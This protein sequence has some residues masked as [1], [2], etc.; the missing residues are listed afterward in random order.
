MLKRINYMKFS[1]ILILSIILGGCASSAGFYSN[2]N[3]DQSAVL[4][5]KFPNALRI[6]GGNEVSVFFVKVDEKRIMPNLMTGDVRE[7]FVE[8]GPHRIIVGFKAG[9]APIRVGCVQVEIV[10][11]AKAVYHF[12]AKPT[13]DSFHLEVWN[14]DSERTEPKLIQ[15]LIAPVTEVVRMQVH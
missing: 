5:S 14:G 4:K 6:V 11:V 15:T 13:A 7:V 2:R 3:S 12:T 9:I 8:P 1:V 10:A